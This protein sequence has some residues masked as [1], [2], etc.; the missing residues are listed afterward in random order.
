MIVLQIF[1]SFLPLAFLGGVAWLI[2]RAAT[3]ERQGV[4]D[5]AVSVRRVI[6]Y[7]LLF[8]TLMLAT[9]GLVELARALSNNTRSNSDLAQALALAIVG[10]PAFMG[11]LFLSDRKLKQSSDERDAASWTV[12]LNLALLVTLIAATVQLHTFAD[13]A[14]GQ[15]AG[16]ERFDTAALMAGL[17]WSAAW[18]FH[19][20]G[21]RRRHGILG[22]FHLAIGTITGLITLAVGLAGVMYVGAYELYTSI[23]DDPSI[24]R[25]GPRIGS[26]AATALVGGGIWTW[27][28]VANF[29]AA[30]R[31]E[32]WHITVVP[33][34]SLAGFVAAVAMTATQLRTVAVWYFGDPIETAA[35]RHFNLLPA[36]SAVLAI[37][38][39][40]WLY[41]RAELVRGANSPPGTHSRNNPQRLYEYLLAG[42]ALVVLVIG[43][44]LV[45]A[46]VLAIGAT[47]RTNPAITGIVMVV[48]G[49]VTWAWH[50]VAIRRAVVVD[51]PTEIGSPIRKV[52]LFALFGS[53]AVATL[54]SFIAILTN[55][56]EDVLN[57]NLSLS[58]LHDNRYS[59]AVILAVAEVAWFHFRL[60]QTERGEDQHNAATATVVRSDIRHHL[61]LVTSE[62]LDALELGTMLN[63]DVELWH[64]DAASA[65]LD[66][67]SLRREIA[68]ESS[69]DLLVVVGSSG[70][71]VIAVSGPHPTP[72]APFPP[73]N[74]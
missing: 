33:I 22:D 9:V 72:L 10:V 45:L 55:S 24:S 54:V 65:R 30:E 5:P 59:L 71:D 46:S 20:F 6:V 53:A 41:H 44:V 11:F 64:R 14:L 7:G 66:I 38:L 13:R 70:F 52:Y 15:D 17:V 63:A 36:T 18:A 2:Y 29:R 43:I 32:T 39:G 57:S 74:P 67:E 25:G 3:G 60:Y 27:Y 19:W 73:M 68:Q 4:E 1:S 34:G 48:V 8:V 69:P 49:T 56:L 16:S 35:A 26:W 42:A 47:D 21:L 58:T 62:P 40:S 61:V 37:G 12:Y 31:T 50:W 28:W 51:R 23:T